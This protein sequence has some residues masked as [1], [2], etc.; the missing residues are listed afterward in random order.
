MV[1]NQPKDWRR[2]CEAAAKEENSEKLMALVSEINQAL[3]QRDLK[4][5]A[6]FRSEE[7]DM[8]NS[9]ARECAA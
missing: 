9:S 2:L 5:E 7:D 8:A 1:A 3:D 4:C 6:V